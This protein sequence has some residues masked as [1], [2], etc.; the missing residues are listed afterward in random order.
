MLVLHAAIS[1][2]RCRRPRTLSA[3]KDARLRSPGSS[4]APAALLVRLA[5]CF[6]PARDFEVLTCQDLPRWSL[7]PPRQPLRKG[8]GVGA[9]V[10]RGP[11]RPSD[12][13]HPSQPEAAACGDGLAIRCSTYPNV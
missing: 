5:G 11:K 6:G 9:V 8:L 4:D 3:K 2:S 7:L 10:E 1:T 12:P 13:P